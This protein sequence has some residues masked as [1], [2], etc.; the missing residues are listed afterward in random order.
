VSGVATL[1]SDEFYGRITQYLAPDGYFVQ[2]MQVYETNLD[3]VASVIKALAPHFGAYALY[4]TDD[5]DILIVASRGAGLQQPDERL[6]QDPQLRTELA[7]VGVQSVADI[8]S[9][10]IGDNLT[11]GPLLQALPVPANS[12]YFPFVDLN[13]PRLRYMGKNAIELPALTVLPIPLRELLEGRAST[14]ATLEPAAIGALF[15]D[16]LVQRA[17]DVR[18]AVSTGNRFNLDPLSAFYLS[19]LD[20]DAS[21]CASK[22][23]QDAWI[24]ALFAISDETAAFLNPGELAGIWDKLRASSCYR[25]ISG[26]PK[27]WAD[28]L[29]AVSQRDALQISRLGTE[30]LGSTSSKSNQELAFLTTVT[31][32]A[33]VGMRDNAQAAQVLQAQWNR[34]D[35]A[36]TFD[37]ALRQLLALTRSAA[38][39]SYAPPRTE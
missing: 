7:R 2:W 3:M 37:L 11:I 6:L 15:R 17:L 38:G 10:K 35:H 16:R 26:E 21:R 39:N 5:S 12:D 14:A 1:F 36:G 24:H 4:N 34:F 13:A 31:A 22:A 32:A 28:L 9:R 19:Q 8:E 30:L 33:L 18:T 23:Q 20:L 29:A 27:K 25:D